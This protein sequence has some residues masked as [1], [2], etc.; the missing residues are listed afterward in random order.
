MVYVIRSEKTDQIQVQ[1]KALQGH[2]GHNKM[3]H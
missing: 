3:M 2:E 1:P